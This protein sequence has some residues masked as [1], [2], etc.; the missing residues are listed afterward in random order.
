MKYS[1]LK[2]QKAM[3]LIELL[4]VIVLLAIISSIGI[5]VFRSLII[6]T[7]ISSFT[8]QLH[9]ALLFAR[10]EAIKRGR[11]VSICRSSNAD[12][13]S[14]TCA[15]P[16]SNPLVNTGW[17]EGWLIYVDMDNDKVYSPSDILIRA[18][19]L[20]I[21]KF[22]A[23]S[24]IP[25]PNRNSVSFNATG[26]TFGAFMRF[27]INRPDVDMDTS[28]DRFI[29]IASGGRARIDTSACK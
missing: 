17:G 15:K 25:V 7:K 11:S 5:P 29:C 4:V 14:P 24:I 12:V 2:Q 19:G 27:A 18:Q 16:L 20:L 13:T 9:A 26:Q 23:G 10:T 8:S 6:T 28:H 3:T 1:Y 21:S 22:D